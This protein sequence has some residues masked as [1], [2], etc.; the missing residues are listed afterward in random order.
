[1]IQAQSASSIVEWDRTTI[2]LGTIKKGDQRADSFSFTN[3]SSEDVEID[4]VSTCE[5]TEAKWTQGGI[6]PGESGKIEFI[7][8]SAAKDNEEPIDI[9]VYFMN[10]DERGDAYS[11]FLSYTFNWQ[12]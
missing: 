2:D 9:D 3:I 7:F 8:D 5:C 10:K 12:K 1:M 6:S 4:I 11:T